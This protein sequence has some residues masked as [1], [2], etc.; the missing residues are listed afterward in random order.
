[1]NSNFKEKG[2]ANISKFNITFIISKDAFGIL[3][4]LYRPKRTWGRW[5]LIPPCSN[6]SKFNLGS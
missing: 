6:M 1:M 3:K 5:F 2:H 4:K